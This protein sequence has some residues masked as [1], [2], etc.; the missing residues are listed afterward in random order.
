MSDAE[1]FK[2]YHVVDISKWTTGDIV[3]RKIT[4]ICLGKSKNDRILEWKG[5][6]S[7]RVYITPSCCKKIAPFRSSKRTNH[8]IQFECQV[9]FLMFL[10]CHFLKH[11]RR[12]KITEKE[13]A[14]SILC[15]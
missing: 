15:V 5:D 12:K 8:H 4:L 7:N 1:L 3:Q 11:F 2:E 10:I 13:T 9:K 14:N 6:F